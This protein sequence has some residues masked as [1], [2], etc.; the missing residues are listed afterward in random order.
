M[1]VVLPQCILYFWSAAALALRA[2]CLSTFGVLFFMLILVYLSQ[3]VLG[4]RVAV[5][6]AHDETS[7]LHPLGILRVETVM[8]YS[9]IHECLAQVELQGR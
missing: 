8:F 9:S 4:L 7:A 2:I 6:S 1:S 3:H 5:F